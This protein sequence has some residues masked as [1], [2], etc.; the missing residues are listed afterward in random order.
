MNRLTVAG[1]EL[2]VPAGEKI[3][4]ISTPGRVEIEY[5]TAFKDGAD[6]LVG[7]NAVLL[8]GMWYPDVKGMQFCRPNGGLNYGIFL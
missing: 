4:R 3:I 1:L 6:S 7:P 2:P 5:T 8:Q